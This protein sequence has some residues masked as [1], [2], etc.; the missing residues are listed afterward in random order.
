MQDCDQIV[1]K[2]QAS[3]TGFFPVFGQ[4]KWARLLSGEDTFDASLARQ[5]TDRVVGCQAPQQMVAVPQMPRCKAWGILPPTHPNPVYGAVWRQF[6][7]ILEFAVFCGY[8]KPGLKKRGY[9]FYIPEF[10]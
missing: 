6:A 9:I 2:S 5:F 4:C 7:I 10:I 3:F 1:I 8:C